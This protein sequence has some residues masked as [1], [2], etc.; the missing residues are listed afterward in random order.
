MASVAQILRRPILLTEKAAS[1]KD[2]LNQFTFEVARDATKYQIRA[3]VQA[4]FSV[5]VLAVRTS[6]VRGKDR[7]MGSGYSRTQNWKKAVVTLKEGQKI[8]FFESTN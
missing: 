6:I 3:A 2:N 1:L 4:A 7:R 8:D 5:D